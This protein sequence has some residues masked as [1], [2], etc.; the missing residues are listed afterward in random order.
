MAKTLLQYKFPD[1]RQEAEA[2]KQMPPD[3]VGKLRDEIKFRLESLLASCDDYFE[4]LVE[5]YCDICG[6][7]GYAYFKLPPG[8]GWLSDGTLICDE[9]Q[10]RWEERFNEAP[11]VNRDSEG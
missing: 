4:N 6:E 11:K 3:R 9:C 8:W 10:R 1:R 2:I 7:Y 5:S